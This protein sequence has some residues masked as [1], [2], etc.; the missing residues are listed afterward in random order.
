[1]GAVWGKQGKCT[2]FVAKIIRRSLYYERRINSHHQTRKKLL[3]N[4]IVGK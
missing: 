1:M 3:F 2:T 4:F